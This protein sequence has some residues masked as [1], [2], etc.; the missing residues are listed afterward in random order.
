MGTNHEN[1]FK[2]QIR[3]HARKNWFVIRI[4]KYSEKLIRNSK[5]QIAKMIRDSDSSPLLFLKSRHPY[6]LI[7]VHFTCHRLSFYLFLFVFSGTAATWRPGSS[8]E[9]NCPTAATVST[10]ETSRSTAAASGTDSGWWFKSR[11]KTP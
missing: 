3:N 9:C 4:M 1:R 10:A 11:P 2:S 8:A 7:F 6:F 5:S